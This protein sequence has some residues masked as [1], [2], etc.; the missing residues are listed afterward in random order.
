MP[1]FDVKMRLTSELKEVRV[2]ADNRY[3]AIAKVVAEA[4]EGSSPEVLACVQAEE[5][6]E[7]E[8]K[9]AKSDKAE[10]KTTAH[11]GRK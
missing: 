9:E 2:E 1:T 6:T 5:P 4:P 11:H 3:Q 8:P 10:H 7:S